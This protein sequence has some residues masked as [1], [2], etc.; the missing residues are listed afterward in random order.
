MRNRW[1]VEVLMEDGSTKNVNWLAAS[2]HR[3][4]DV[5]MKHLMLGW[6][7]TENAKPLFAM[8]FPANPGLDT[9]TGIAH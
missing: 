6:A 9:D 2:A 3:A 1:N 7:M 4:V 5:A 8:A